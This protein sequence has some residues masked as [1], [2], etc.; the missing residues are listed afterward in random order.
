MDIFV[1][2]ILAYLHTFCTI[3]FQRGFLSTEEHFQLR[4][5]A[6]VHFEG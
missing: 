5:K 2:M 3:S 1:C 4:V 6:M